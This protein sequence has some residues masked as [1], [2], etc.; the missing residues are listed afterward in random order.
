MNYENIGGKFFSELHE[1]A[2]TAMLVLAGVHVAGV[3]LSSIL[4]RENLVAAML[5]GHKRGLQAEGIARPHRIVAALLVGGL[6]LFAVL[7]LRGNLPSVYAPDAATPS[8]A[9]QRGDGD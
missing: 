3:L 5:S 2:A 6:I 8:R 4:H 1:G 9:Q 7:A